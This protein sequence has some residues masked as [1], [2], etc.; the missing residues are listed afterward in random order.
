MDR[1]AFEPSEIDTSG[2]TVAA[3]DRLKDDK[4]TNNE[5]ST[6]MYELFTSL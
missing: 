5:D 1:L 6:G 3:V 2:I 4:V